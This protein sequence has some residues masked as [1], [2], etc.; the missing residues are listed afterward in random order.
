MPLITTPSAKRTRD[1]L[2]LSLAFFAALSRADLR[3][4][5][6]PEPKQEEK[7]KIFQIPQV[8]K[9]K[10]NGGLHYPTAVG[11]RQDG[12][13]PCKSGPTGW[14][15]RVARVSRLPRW[16]SKFDRPAA[17]CQHSGHLLSR[18]YKINTST[19]P[20]VKRCQWICKGT[21]RY[22]NLP[23]DDWFL[24]TGYKTET[25]FWMTRKFHFARL[26]RLFAPILAGILVGRRFVQVTV[27]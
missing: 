12:P 1:G 8:S 23:D 14:H 18:T 7:G 4:D 13:F 9:R 27:K 21:H 16:S 25:E 3:V 6:K 17:I 5:W 2:F 11:K 22:D 24:A 26:W 19:Q 20:F 10:T 15:D